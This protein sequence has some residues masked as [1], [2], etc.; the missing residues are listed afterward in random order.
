MVVVGLQ[1]FGVSAHAGRMVK[2]LAFW[3][4]FFA[5]ALLIIP[6]AIGIWGA[7]DEFAR[8]VA[9]FLFGAISILVILLVL[10][11][12]CRDWLLRRVLGTVATTLSDVTGSLVK[13]V[14]AAANGDRATAEKEAQ[15][16]ATAA[17]GWY[18]WSGFYRW[19]IASALGLLLAFGAFTGTVLLFEQNRKLSEQTVLLGEQGALMQAQTDRMAEQTTQV[20]MQNEIM[21]ISLVSE[22]REQSLSTTKSQTQRTFFSFSDMDQKVFQGVESSCGVGWDP[23]VVLTSVPSQSIINAIVDIAD[24]RKIS[25]QIV[26]ALKF[27]LTDSES[28]VAFGA[29]Q[30]LDQL[31][32][33]SEDD[34]PADELIGAGFQFEGL[35]IR[36]VHFQSAYPI[37][38]RGSYLESLSCPGCLL[39]IYGS[40]TLYVDVDSQTNYDSYVFGAFEDFQVGTNIVVSNGYDGIPVDSL[41]LR[42]GPAFPSAEFQSVALL[43]ADASSS[44]FE[45]EAFSEFNRLLRYIE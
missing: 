36:D 15:A 33:L 31:G 19:V 41:E 14:S 2:H 43:D 39:S 25:G 7:A 35:V 17:T 42:F 29:M 6:V 44:C 4:G 34:F 12:F 37:L 16:F 11:L 8:N 18:V 45:L 13:G 20:E 40:V 27:L 24:D 38:I 30:A 3:I 22:L 28:A 1:F 26:T 9:V 5:S 23:D 10:G 32:Q 21:T